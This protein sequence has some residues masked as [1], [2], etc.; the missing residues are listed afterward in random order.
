MYRLVKKQIKGMV[1]EK[2]HR[3]RSSCQSKA[4][5]SQFQFSFVHSCLNFSLNP[6]TLDIKN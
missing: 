6:K 2:Y 5:F 3:N 1:K 4:Q